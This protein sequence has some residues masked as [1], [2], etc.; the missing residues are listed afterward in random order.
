MA[1]ITIAG[2][3]IKKKQPTW[4]PNPGQ[5]TRYQLSYNSELKKESFYLTY[6]VTAKKVENK[7][8]YYKETLECLHLIFW[9]RS[10]RRVHYYTSKLEPNRRVTI[11]QVAVNIC[12]ISIVL[13]W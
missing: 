5:H 1:S 9:P 11:S 6:K 8:V 10:L 7:I 13:D 12:D 4:E 3:V 2:M